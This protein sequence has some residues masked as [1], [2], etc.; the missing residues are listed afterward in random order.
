MLL[1]PPPPRPYR[2]DGYGDYIFAVSRLTPL[3]RLDLLIRALALPAA[4]REPAPSSPAR[5][6]AA[7][8]SNSSIV[9][10]RPVRP[11]AAWRA[12]SPTMRCSITMRGA[13]RCVSRRSTRTT[14]SSRSR[15]LR[16]ERASL[17][18]RRQRRTRRPR[19]RRRHRSRV[20][21][22][23]RGPGARPR[24]RHGRCGVRGADRRRGAPRVAD[25]DLGG[26]GPASRDRLAGA[27]CR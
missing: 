4:R 10:A 20:R 16:R 5:A 7:P 11:R 2:C 25:D 1:P 18:C 27:R 17:T 24:A 26:S 9:D 8:R 22:D 12:G 3:K 23:A 21:A 19:P 13:A 15:R 14:G 6:R